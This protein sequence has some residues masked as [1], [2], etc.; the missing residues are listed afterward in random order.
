MRNFSGFLL[1]GMSV[2]VVVGRSYSSGVAFIGTHHRQRVSSTVPASRSRFAGLSARIVVSFFVFP[3]IKQVTAP[4]TVSQ[5][6][7]TLHYPLTEAA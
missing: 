4:S 2:Q 6:A 7:T 5:P 1:I 3:V